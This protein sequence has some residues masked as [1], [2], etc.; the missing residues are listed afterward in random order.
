MEKVVLK[1]GTELS[2][3]NG[4]TENSLTMPIT[5]ENNLEKLISV[6]TEE[7]L[8][9]Y[10]ILNESGEECTTIFDKYVK[11]YTVNT[12]ENTVRFDLANVDAVSKRLTNLE[13]TQELQD[14]AI[15]ELAEMVAE[16]EG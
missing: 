3:Q 6:M 16:Q 10:K 12:E 1:D 13:T 11:T 2:I 9:E 7:N 8:A 14:E 4:A 15:T 5:E